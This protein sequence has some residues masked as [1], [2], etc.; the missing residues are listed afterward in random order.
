MHVWVDVRAY[1]RVC[2]CMYVWIRSTCV[3]MCVSVYVCMDE[4]MHMRVRRYVCFS[5]NVCM[6][7][8]VFV[9]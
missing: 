9:C 4:C 6:H 1:V 8:C 5:V 2:L 7:V 3:L